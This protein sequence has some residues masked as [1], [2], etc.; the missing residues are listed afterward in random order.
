[1]IFWSGLFAKFD[2]EQLV[3]GANTMLRVAKEIL[4]AQTA[5][6]VNRLLLQDGESSEHEE[7]DPAQAYGV[8]AGMRMRIVKSFGLRLLAGF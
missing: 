2:H 5:R 1:M 8:P 6:Q 4:A 7:E 3:E